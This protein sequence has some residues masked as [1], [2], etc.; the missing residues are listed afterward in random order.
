LTHRVRGGGGGRRLEA[1]AA[2]RARTSRAKGSLRI[3]RSVDRWYLRISRSATVPGRYLCG[4]LIAPPSVAAALPLPLVLLAPFALTGVAPSP[5]PS[6][7]RDG[8]CGFCANGSG[9]R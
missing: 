3:S 2:R 6:D 8:R 7:G 9:E 5:P 1:A 4:F